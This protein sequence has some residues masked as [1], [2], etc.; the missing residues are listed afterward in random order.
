[1]KDE[2]AKDFLDLKRQ[3]GEVHFDALNNR[4]SRRSRQQAAEQA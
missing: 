2:L 3:I 4:S 1:L